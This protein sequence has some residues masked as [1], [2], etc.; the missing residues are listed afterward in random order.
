[1]LLQEDHWV[2]E[3]IT[4]ARIAYECWTVLLNKKIEIVPDGVFP[5]GDGIRVQMV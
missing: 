2:G 4:H 1:M 5:L 3:A